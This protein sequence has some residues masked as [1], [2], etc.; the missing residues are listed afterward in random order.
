MKRILLL[1]DMQYGFTG[2]EQTKEVAGRIQNL[3][4]LG[5]FDLVIATRFL[6]EDN[7][8]YEQLLGW[9]RLKIESERAIIN[10]YS[11]YIDHIFDK[12]LYTCVDRNFLQ[13]VYQLNEGHYPE[14]IYVAGADTDC[15]V[16]KVAT[17]L[18][19]NS[20]RPVVLTK[21]CASNGG[22]NSHEAGLLCMRRLV[23][24]KQLVDVEIDSN[25]DL[26]II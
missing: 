18:F 7:S 24:E 11:K 25:T 22:Q 3:L 26:S 14:K 16:L 9:N 6:N 21:Y 10:G 2:N 23:G 13:K 4:D 1:V 17:D 12:Y 15:C 5:L 8:M 19:E 20:I